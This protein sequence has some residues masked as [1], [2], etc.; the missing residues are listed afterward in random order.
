MVVY[1]RTLN[2]SPLAISTFSWYVFLKF[3]LFYN[4]SLLFICFKYSSVYVSIPNYQSIPLSTLP[5]PTIN[6]FSKSV[7]LFLFCK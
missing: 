5:S 2:C 6:S 7:G 4:G 3:Y 1:R